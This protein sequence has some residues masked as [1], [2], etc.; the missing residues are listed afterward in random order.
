M[1]AHLAKPITLADLARTLADH[2]PASL[3]STNNAARDL[4]RQPEGISPALHTLD[5]RYRQRKQALAQRI[6]A[7]LAAEPQAIDWAKI[8]AELHKLAGVAANFG[9]PRLGDLSRQL[10]RQLQD[11]SLAEQRQRLLAALWPEW[12]DAA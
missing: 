2:A 11:A 6:E 9:E 10:E 12:R 5:H 7:T 1:Q 4:L 3:A 8:T